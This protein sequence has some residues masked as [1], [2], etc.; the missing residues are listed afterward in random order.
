MSEALF[1]VA[2]PKQNENTVIIIIKGIPGS[3]K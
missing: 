3:R 1:G 2:Q